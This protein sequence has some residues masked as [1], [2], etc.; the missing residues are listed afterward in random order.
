MWVGGPCVCVGVPAARETRHFWWTAFS[1]TRSQ[2]LQETLEVHQERT[3]LENRFLGS[4]MDGRPQKVALTKRDGKTLVFRKPTKKAF[5]LFAQASDQQPSV[6]ADSPGVESPPRDSPVPVSMSQNEG[7]RVSWKTSPDRKKF[8]PTLDRKNWALHTSDVDVQNEISMMKDVYAGLEAP[9]WQGPKEP[10]AKENDSGAGV[11]DARCGSSTSSIGKGKLE[12]RMKALSRNNQAKKKR[13]RAAPGGHGIGVSTA[14]SKASSRVSLDDLLN[15]FDVRQQSKAPHAPQGPAVVLSSTPPREVSNNVPNGSGLHVRETVAP[16]SRPTP[17]A[18]PTLEAEKKDIDVDA[19]TDTFGGV[20]DAWALLAFE[21][22]L[23]KSKGVEKKQALA[24]EGS[25]AEASPDYAARPVPLK[26]MSCTRTAYTR[27]VITSSIT[28]SQTETR[29]AVKVAEDFSPTPVAVEASDDLSFSSPLIVRLRGIWA[30]TPVETKDAINVV[31]DAWPSPGPGA[32]SVAKTLQ[33]ALQLS[34]I[35]VDDEHHWIIV[36]PDILISPSIVGSASKCLRQAILTSNVRDSASSKACTMGNLKHDLFEYAMV[37]EDFS[38]DGLR[39]AAKRIMSSRSEECCASNVTDAEASRSLYS[40]LPKIV[41]WAGV[42]MTSVARGKP[43]VQMDPATPPIDRV[44]TSEEDIVSP[45]WGLRARPDVSVAVSCTGPA[46]SHSTMLPGGVLPLELKTGMPYQAHEAQAV[47]YGVAFADRYGDPN[48]YAGPP[49]MSAQSVPAA[50]QSFEAALLVYLGLKDGHA[51]KEKTRAI[52][53]KRLELQALLDLRNRVARASSSQKHEMVTTSMNGGAV[54]TLIPAGRLLPTVIERVNTCGSCYVRDACALY[55]KAWEETGAEGT[56]KS[57]KIRELFEESVGHLNE[58]EIKYFQKFSRLLDLEASTAVNSTRMLW[59]VPPK[60]RE[61]HG[62]CAADLLLDPPLPMQPGV[63]GEELFAYRFRRTP[64]RTVNGDLN[65]ETIFALGDKVALSVQHAHIALGRGTVTAVSGS[66]VDVTTKSPLAIP[67]GQ[68]LGSKVGP[69]RTGSILWSMDKDVY[70]SSL[71]SERQNMRR[72]LI[73]PPPLFFFGGKKSDNMDDD[74]KLLRALITERTTRLR[75]LVVNTQSPQFIERFPANDVR[76]PAMWSG[77]NPPAGCGGDEIVEELGLMNPDQITAFKLCTNAKDYAMILGMPGTGKTTL[78]ALLVRAFL[79]QGKRVLLSSF[80]NSA[81]DNML[82][83]LKASN[84]DFVRVGNEKSVHP[85]IRPF[86]IRN[87]VNG[88][89]KPRGGISTIARMQQE[90]QNAKLVATTC[91]SCSSALMQKMYFDVCIVDEAS[92]I[93]EPTCLGPLHLAKVFVLVGDHH[94]LTAVVKSP[95]ARKEGLDISLFKRLSTFHPHA[96]ATL[97]FQYRMNEDIMSLSNQLV[98]NNQLKCGSAEVSRQTLCI[99]STMLNDRAVLPLP[100]VEGGEDAGR[101]ARNHWLRDLLNPAQPVVFADT[102]GIGVATLESRAA[103][104][105]HAFSPDSKVSSGELI[106]RIEASLVRTCIAGFVRCNVALEDVGVICPYRSQL[107]LLKTHEFL[108]KYS[109]ELEVET[110]DKYQ[111]RDK[112]CII[113]SLVRSNTSAVVGRLLKDLKRI[114]VAFTR[115][116]CKL[117]IFGSLK[118]LRGCSEEHMSAFVS[119]IEER[120][121]VHKLPSNA[122]T[123]Y[124]GLD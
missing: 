102:D 107:K 91:L 27:F 76:T 1:A 35:I 110:V 9:G 66:F 122:H 83:K 68:D 11:L 61:T 84:T 103:V 57:T 26:S 42:H 115:A 101:S 4:A 8:Q 62:T 73:G 121:W 3:V 38:V 10:G 60:D 114:N 58:K 108:G 33:E 106:N 94:Q 109:D 43:Q 78:I 117:I 55:H 85:S 72:M 124:D 31:W 86:L 116:K 50:S 48:Q 118:T 99:P 80:T 2:S 17:P 74:K 25:S 39:K 119:F 111:G 5:P 24:S 18:R 22:T 92:Q 98:Y 67:S 95:V 90:L 14:S 82:L 6:T 120:K 123:F 23:K 46:N 21:E 104:S 30:Q 29:F 47:L 87:K 59:R 13:R 41:K 105:T 40:F 88:K 19:D 70:A 51:E 65:Y 32:A 97:T 81:V 34:E 63:Q 56:I 89:L 53:H 15:D 54:D 37:H 75:N 7:F 93:T 71:K 44:L 36:C 45:M 12:E 52:H 64:D 100:R 28:A 77:G 16:D 96:L 69:G 49:P 113:V 20:D 79:N 112:P